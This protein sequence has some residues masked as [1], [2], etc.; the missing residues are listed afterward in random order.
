M[1]GLATARP[2][3]ARSSRAMPRSPQTPQ[4]SANGSVMECGPARKRVLP[5]HGQ[6]YTRGLVYSLDSQS[7]TPH[8]RRRLAATYL[9]ES[10]VRVL[11]VFPISYRQSSRDL[12]GNQPNYKGFRPESSVGRANPARISTRLSVSNFCLSRGRL[13]SPSRYSVIPR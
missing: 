4:M 7:M 8:S 10:P 6:S 9:Y 1:T 11:S 5:G 2:L 13:R 12:L 3:R